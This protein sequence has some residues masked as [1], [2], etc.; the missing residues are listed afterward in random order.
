M[1]ASNNLQDEDFESNQE[2]EDSKS[3]W[4]YGEENK[5]SKSNWE[6]EEN[7]D[8]NEEIDVNQYGYVNMFSMLSVTSPTKDNGSTV[9]S[10]IKF[11]R[12]YLW[13]MHLISRSGMRFFGDADVH[14]YV[15]ILESRLGKKMIKYHRKWA[16]ILAHH[17]PWHISSHNPNPS[18]ETS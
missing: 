17:I 18:R 1:T 14:F 7:D 4:E 9:S 3:N 15:W 12:N 13:K 6:Y 2:N 8:S 11:S 10:H 16:K 5:D